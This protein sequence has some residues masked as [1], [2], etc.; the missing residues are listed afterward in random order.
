MDKKKNTT[1]IYVF[2]FIGEF[3]EELPYQEVTN[4]YFGGRQTTLSSCLTRTSLYKKFYYFLRTKEFIV[5]QKK[6]E[7]NPLRTKH[8]YYKHK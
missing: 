3:I 2:N 6:S 5:K 7:H 4:K 1:I 8:V